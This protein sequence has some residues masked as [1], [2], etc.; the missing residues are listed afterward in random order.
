MNSLSHWKISVHGTFLRNGVNKYKLPIRI[1]FLDDHKL[2]RKGLLDFVIKPFYPFAKIIEISNG[3]IA[4]SK[5]EEMIMS[6]TVPDIIFTDINHSG[7][8]GYEF[9]KAVRAFEHLQGKEKLIPIIVV[10]MTIDRDN[11]EWKEKANYANVLYFSK[12]DEGEEIIEAM[13]Q[14][15]YE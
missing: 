10:S 3:D 7:L 14:L 13:E 15:L 11:Q 8:S 6:H 4:L 5:V 9:I 1:L 2:F 12:A